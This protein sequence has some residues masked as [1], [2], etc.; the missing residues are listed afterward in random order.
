MLFAHFVGGV[1]RERIETDVIARP[2]GT[3]EGRA[4]PAATAAACASAQVVA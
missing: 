3:L 2:A 4:F 1:G